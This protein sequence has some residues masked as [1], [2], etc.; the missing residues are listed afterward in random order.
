MIWTY[1]AISRYLQAECQWKCFHSPLLSVRL[2]KLLLNN[3][4]K[5]FEAH[6]NGFEVK[7]AFSKHGMKKDLVAF[8]SNSFSVYATGKHFAHLGIVLHFRGIVMDRF[9]G[10][11]NEIPVT[12]V[13]TQ[14]VRHINDLFWLCK[15]L[16]WPV[17][18]LMCS[19]PTN[20]TFKT[21]SAVLFGGYHNS[22]LHNIK[23]G[24]LHHLMN[25]L[26]EITDLSYMMG[27]MQESWQNDLK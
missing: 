16:E 26:N 23:W 25:N 19:E 13:R 22:A 14:Y 11:S 5:P 8:S 12:T 15:P 18:D 27:D 10:L 1:Y 21:Y 2:E 6:S 4:R 17:T 7:P 3:L 9:C 20:T 24:M